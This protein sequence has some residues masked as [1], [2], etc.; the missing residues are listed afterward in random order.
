MAPFQLAH[1][2]HVA[3]NSA[4]PTAS[5]AWYEKVLG[6][7]KLQLAAWGDYPI[8]MLAGTVGV[9]IFK[10][11]PSLPPPPPARK[12]VRIDHFAFNV[13]LEGFAKARRH[14]EQL[15]LT[16]H[17]RDHQYFHSLYTNDPDG[18]TVE[19]TTLVVAEQEVYGG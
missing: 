13:S 11:D 9:A 7:Q 2:D 6:L 10:A 15:G 19:L 4:D 14:Y 16:Y 1:L 18:H 17:F 5:V 3:I 12:S 8:F